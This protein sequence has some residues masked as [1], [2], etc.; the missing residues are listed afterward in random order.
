MNRCNWQKNLIFL[1]KI[2]PKTTTV[3]N[4]RESK[5]VSKRSGQTIYHHHK[6]VDK[7]R[8]SHTLLSLITYLKGFVKIQTYL[9]LYQH[10]TNMNLKKVF[11]RWS[12]G[13]LIS[14]WFFEVVNFLQKTN[15]NNSH[16]IKNEIICLFFGGNRW[17]QNHY[18]INW[19][20]V[21]NNAPLL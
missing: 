5:L 16:R 10:N 12:K 8:V 6:W 2:L 9:S 3:V 7:K 21:H 14:K 13:E 20:L 17:P 11:V 19:P 15:K 18:D 1:D 4:E